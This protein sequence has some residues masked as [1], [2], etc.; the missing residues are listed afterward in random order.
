[1]KL[2]W[3]EEVVLELRLLDSESSFEISQEIM[4]GRL[5]SREKGILGETSCVR[6]A[7]PP[8]K[9]VVHFGKCESSIVTG[10]Q[11]A[12]GGGGLTEAGSGSRGS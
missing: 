7:E 6:P 11:W 3:N 10:T 2:S 1:M 5:L 9:V 8:D 4:D 12:V